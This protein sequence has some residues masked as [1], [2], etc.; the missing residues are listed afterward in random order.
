MHNEVVPQPGERDEGY[1]QGTSVGRTTAPKCSP[2]S[3]LDPRRHLS[4]GFAGMRGGWRGDSNAEYKAVTGSWKSGWEQILVATKRLEDTWG[5]LRAVA[6]D[7][8]S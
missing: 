7:N 5:Q 6:A 8:R 3:L 1:A 2:H 4:G